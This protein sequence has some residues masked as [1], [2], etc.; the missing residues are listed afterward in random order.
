MHRSGTSLLTRI[1]NIH[2]LDLGDP[3]QLL[4]A[5][6]T[7][8]PTG[9]WESLEV[10]QINDEIL[11]LFGGN[12]KSPP[13]FPPSW[14]N[15][16]RLDALYSRAKQFSATMNARADLWGFK[17]PRVCITLPFW[18]KCIPDMQFII[19]LRN[20]LAISQSLYKRDSLPVFRSVYLW[21]RYW[22]DAL[23]ATENAPRVFV[24][25]SELVH[26]W[27]T[28][29]EP[30]ISFLGIENESEKS[31]Q[32]KRTVDEHLSTRLIHH[33]PSTPSAA[34]QW[35]SSNQGTD[36]NRT[37]IQDMRA[38]MK[39]MEEDS[40]SIIRKKN[41]YTLELKKD[42][43]LLQEKIASQQSMLDTQE[44]TITQLRDEKNAAQQRIRFMEASSFWKLR[45]RYLRI[46]KFLTTKS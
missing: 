17:D 10:I 29:I 16:K 15:D 3:E 40:R 42:M 14:E 43:H 30:V 19:A 41:D 22:M 45:N 37:F 25:F 9:H 39:L 34:E 18:Q 44:R 21:N 7:S 36:L 24:L 28:A 27:Q 20:P 38:S 32:N 26:N 31:E 11:Q 5:N 6:D 46:K 33:E 35:V 4:G 8:N 2:G 12:W 13:T 1:L 23:E